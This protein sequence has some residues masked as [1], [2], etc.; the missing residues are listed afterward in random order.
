MTLTNRRLGLLMIFIAAT[1]YAF[2]PVFTR[3][4]YAVSDLQPTDIAL[5]R[6]AFAT[7]AIWL[8]IHLRGATPDANLPRNKLLAL[9]IVYS[10]ATLT[11]FFGLQ[12]I[13][14]SLYVVLFYTYPAMVT[15]IA[16]ATGTRLTLVAWL[17]LVLTLIGVV[18]TVPDF[19][20]GGETDLVGVGFALVNAVVV[21]VYFVL[22]GKLMRGTTSV[23]RGS[24]W[25]ITGT[26]LVLLLTIPFFGLQLPPTPQAWLLLL[27]LGTV[28]TALPIFAMNTGIQKVGA[29]KAS[30]I[31]AVEPVEAML[32]AVLLLGEVV[33]PVQWVGAGFIVAAVI[34]LE[35]RPKRR[36]SV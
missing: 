23:A 33:L 3:T 1:G 6:F 19:N 8:I 27:G 16:F 25:V 2:L 29:A 10:A 7:P 5:W 36:K 14:A 15:L 9:G 4:L 20:L 35:W 21:A 32:L 11:G 18:L 30:I 26:L 13:E 34:L 22:V 12:R 24:A 17:A 28:S 31:S